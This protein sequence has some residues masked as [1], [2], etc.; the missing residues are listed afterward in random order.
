M[1]CG[2]WSS[3]K[4]IFVINKLDFS[5]SGVS[6]DLSLANL[7]YGQQNDIFASNV[8]NK[9]NS[10]TWDNFSDNYTVNE[11][12][13]EINQFG[14]KNKTLNT[15]SGLTLNEADS[16]VFNANNDWSK[17]SSNSNDK[18]TGLSNS[19]Y[20]RAENERTELYTT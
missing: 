18:L 16:R 20:R 5:E 6:L 13:A 15:L 7:F 3:V 4:L 12:L 11:N 2:L 9:I 1:N 10:S 8:N 14:N 19:L 17:F